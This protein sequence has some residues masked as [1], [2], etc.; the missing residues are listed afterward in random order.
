MKYTDHERRHAIEYGSASGLYLRIST[1]QHVPCHSCAM[2][3]SQVDDH[4][5][6]V[7][8][9]MLQAIRRAASNDATVEPSYDT[10]PALFVSFYL[11]V[12]KVLF[13]LE[14]WAEN[15]VVDGTVT[16]G[17]YTLVSSI[18]HAVDLNTPGSARKGTF[19][20]PAD[21][22]YASSASGDASS[23]E[24]VAP[25]ASSLFGEFSFSPSTSSS[26][27]GSMP[28]HLKDTFQVQVPQ[29]RDQD[30]K[31][32]RRLAGFITDS[33]AAQDL[34]DPNDGSGLA[35]LR[36]WRQDYLRARTR[37]VFDNTIENLML[38]VASEGLARADTA[39]FNRLRGVLNLL[40]ESLSDGPRKSAVAMANLTVSIV[41][42]Y[43]ETLEQ[44]L[45]SHQ[46]SRIFVQ[47]L[48]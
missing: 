12:Q 30:R 38:M 22:I 45:R 23:G 25:A 39:S 28:G 21:L 1:N 31:L 17:R 37:T 43:S 24:G 46:R 32:G 8:K 15:L 11:H 35:I 13:N 7:L 29:I 34:L 9:Q 27:A 26:P 4:A 33:T 36:Q 41:K 47:L 44:A 14:P 42:D 16:S 3:R 48:N 18:Q 20:N 10:T 19:G 6:D 5:M 40:N 2:P